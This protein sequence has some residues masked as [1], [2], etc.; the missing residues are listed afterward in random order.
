MRRPTNPY[1]GPPHRTGYLPRAVRAF[2]EQHGGIASTSELRSL[3]VDP[4]ALEIY[5]D[6]G[7]LQAVRQGWHCLPSVPSVVRLAW[8]FGGPLA[9]VSALEFYRGRP[10][11]EDAA[12]ALVTQPLHVC[13]PGNAARIPS[14]ELLARRWGIAEP[15]PPVIHWSTSDYRSGD[16]RAVSPAAALRH[17]DRCDL[18]RAVQERGLP[19]EARATLAPP[20]EAWAT[21]APANEAWAT[22]APA[23]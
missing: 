15:M 22:R 5:R 19:E 2:L 21:R 20:E 13:L 1:C 3:D 4:T 17:A 18:R 16:R 9:C 23:A 10:L 7:A 8:R 11:G 14:P 12:A 6:Y